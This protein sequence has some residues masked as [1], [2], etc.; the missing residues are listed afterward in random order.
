LA[1]DGRFYG[2]ASVL[3]AATEAS[4]PPEESP[5]RSAMSLAQ[6]SRNARSDGAGRCHRVELRGAVDGSVGR[7][8]S[9]PEGS[10]QEVRPADSW[11]VGRWF[12]SCPAHIAKD[13]ELHAFRALATRWNRRM[14]S[15]GV[16]R[17]A[18]RCATLA[19]AGGG[20]VLY[21]AAV[22]AG[23]RRATLAQH[24]RRLARLVGD[25]LRPEKRS[26]RPC[27]AFAGIWSRPEVRLWAAVPV[28]KARPRRPA[29]RWRLRLRP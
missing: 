22:R 5:M 7:W 1:A 29:W 4:A 9:V 19:R 11:S 25:R 10:V 23:V 14:R 8:A 27:A 26:R 20:A 17:G 18:T 12:E 28:S 6:P 2:G 16:T 3:Q 24:R 15:A 21:L 13:L